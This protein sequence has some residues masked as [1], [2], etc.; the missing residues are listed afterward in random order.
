MAVT[1]HALGASLFQDQEQQDDEGFPAH[2]TDPV[3][4]LSPFASDLF[5]KDCVIRK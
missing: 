3:L 5:T 1:S 2:G 4:S